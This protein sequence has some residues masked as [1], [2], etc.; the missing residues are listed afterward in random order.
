MYLKLTKFSWVRRSH[1]LS[2]RTRLLADKPWAGGVL[3][4]LCVVVAMTLANLEAT[5]S[6]YHE[7]LT[8]DFSMRIHSHGGLFNMSFPR[9]MTVETF[10]NDA[11]MMIFFFSVGLEIKREV[12]H[13][14][15]SSVQRSILPVMA[16]LGGMIVPAV[17]Y[18]S[19]NGGTP[20]QG[21]WGVPMATDIAFA[22]GILSMLGDRV[23]L[24][25]KIFLTALAVADDLGAIIV[26]ALFYGGGV[27]FTY[28]LIAAVIML[29]VYAI[30]RMGE[31]HLVF[32][33]VAALVVWSLF[34]YSG[35]H[36]TLSG[37]VM[38]MLIPTEPRYSKQYFLR[39]A[40]DLEHGIVEAASGEDTEFKEEHYYEQLRRMTRLTSGSIP[41]SAKLENTLAPYIT[42]MIM[43]IFALVNGGV[44]INADQ[45]DIFSYSATG[46]SIGLGV[47]LGLLIGKPV[48]I[49]LMSWLAVK[50][51]LAELPSSSSWLMLFS[52]ACLGGIGFT[53]SIFVDTLAFGSISM[54]YVDS[55]KIAILA[56]SLASAVVGVVL[57][58][59]TSRRG[60]KV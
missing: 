19:L 49:F 53:M 59:L 45:L 38:A 48:G 57:I 43:P 29:F 56:G 18:A 23:P 25:L 26:I 3:L 17:I 52:V 51:K 35:V 5:A 2:E 11:L 13:G 31:R 12:M 58:L 4:I 1:Q 50:F 37:V 54:D 40:D 7:F 47:F 27:N 36:A 39:Q 8:T 22:V 30:N 16:A 34:Y 15:L 46:G 9:N 20:V 6:A 33:I 28:L 14:E 32:Y 21:G 42:F 60:A 41:M 55:G 10:V 44:H 24:S